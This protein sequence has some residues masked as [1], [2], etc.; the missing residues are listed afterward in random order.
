MP[1]I[2]L[3]QASRLSPVP[4]GAS[5]VPLL[6]GSASLLVEFVVLP[7][8]PISAWG[9]MWTIA[10]TL[11]ATFKWLS[12]MHRP[13]RSVPVSPA[14]RWAYFV[15]WVG[16]DADEFFAPPCPVP[17]PRWHE[18]GLAAGKTVS[19]AVL[20][21]GVVPW[22]HATVPLATGV[23]GI[24][25]LALFLH[26]GLFHVLALAWRVAGTPVVPIMRA[27]LAATSLADF[28][29]RRWNR[30]YRHVSH[31]AF[32]RPCVRQLGLTGGTLAAFGISGVVHD[33]VISIP[34][35]GGYGGPTIYFLLQG[36]ALLVEKLP[37]VA[38]ALRR[39]RWAGWCWTVVMVVGPLRL[40]FHHPF[41][42][43]VIDPFLLAIGAR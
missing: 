37:P 33:L 34:A 28:W 14:R 36:L 39:Q 40:L 21:W 4:Q 11:F 43:N 35:R 30:A 9:A 13:G 27:P 7:S 26:F 8:L 10:F 2:T 1:A 16:L 3:Q 32:F 5:T 42:M 20:L 23:V 17:P 38:G 22:V 6:C 24:V 31:A 41:L 25:G 19:G 15:G 18:W 12:W 29:G